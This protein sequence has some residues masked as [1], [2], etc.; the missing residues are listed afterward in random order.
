MEDLTSKQN[1]ANEIIRREIPI[2]E[3]DSTIPAVLEPSKIISKTNI[4]EHVVVCFFSEVI[5]KL[6]NEGKAN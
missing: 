2:L 1:S 4:P 5:E 6:K 3:F